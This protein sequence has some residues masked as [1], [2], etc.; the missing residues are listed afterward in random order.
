M[1]IIRNF[2][3]A[4]QV[5]TREIPAEFTIA[6]SDPGER[7]KGPG[8]S[9]EQIVTT[10]IREVRQKGDIALFDYAR[11]FDEAELNTLLVTTD[12]IKA[13]HKQVDEQLKSALRL[14]AKRI[15][16]FHT[17]CNNNIEA[18]FLSNGAGRIAR[19][20]SKV[21][22]YVPGGTAAYPSTV[23]MSALPA[24]VAGVDKVFIATPPR[25]DGTIHP[26]TLVAADMTKVDLII[27]SGGAQAIAALAFGTESIPKVDKICGPGNIFVAKAKQLV[28][29]IVDIDG[30][31]GP[32]EIAVVADDTANASFCAADLIAQSEHDTMAT[33]VFITTS[34]QLAD[35]V[36]TEI[37]TQLAKL[38]RK[39]IAKKA[40]SE[41][42]IIAIVDTMDEAIEL[43][44]CFAPEH[45]SLMV[46]NAQSYIDKIRNAGCVL[47]N[48]NSPVTMGDYIA[49]PSH[50]LPTS[51][52]ARFSSS[53]GIEDFYKFINIVSLDE[54]E[55][56]ALGP[57]TIAMAESEGLTGH[58][59][60][61]R[62]RLQAKTRGTSDD[63][64]R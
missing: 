59:Q 4:K 58:A 26:A 30:I 32:S 36:C 56:E 5:L 50:V 37:N 27:K 18:Y 17:A 1:K 24:R 60:A 8:T 25:K 13:A 3:D 51:G 53:L 35:N 28:Y 52:T 49:G 43:V 10:I 46:Y 23:L 22:L 38:K 42:G 29:G 61:I 47:V 57:A 63:I 31:Q 40:L 62:I 48:S 6:R 15:T 44:N 41:N 7:D 14:A 19:P 20:L 9:V 55:F 33:S 54:K 21:G 11:K 45:L 2:N 12:E 64:D 16:D 39:A 34:G